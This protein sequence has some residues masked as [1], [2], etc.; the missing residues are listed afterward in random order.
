MT[1]L[2]RRHAEQQFAEELA[3]LQ[4]VDDRPR[5]PNWQLS[6]WAVVTYLLGGELDNAIRWMS[7]KGVRVSREFPPP[8]CGHAWPPARAGHGEPRRV[9]Y[10]R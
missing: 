3:A 6:P 9:G 5:P 10:E 8:C 7:Y 1:D 2:L 4:A